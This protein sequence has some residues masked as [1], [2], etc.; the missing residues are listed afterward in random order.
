METDLKPACGFGFYIG[1]AWIYKDSGT[2][3]S[4]NLLNT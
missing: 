1:T 4:I 2:D 3:R